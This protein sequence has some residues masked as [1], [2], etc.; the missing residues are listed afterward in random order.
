MFTPETFSEVVAF[1]KLP[2]FT[3]IGAFTLYVLN[4]HNDKQPF[5]LF[6]A[7]NINVGATGL[8]FI[9]FLDIVF[10]SILGTVVVIPL[11]APATAAQALAAGLG[12]TGILSVRAKEA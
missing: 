8:P 9:I 12:M 6:R 5:S 3:F 1:L 10:T 2:V 4:R 11:T 7:L